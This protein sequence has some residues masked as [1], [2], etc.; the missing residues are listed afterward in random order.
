MPLAGGLGMNASGPPPIRA[1]PETRPMICYSFSRDELSGD[2]GEGEELLPGSD[3]IAQG[4]QQ[5]GGDGAGPGGLHT[6]DGH[7]GVLG[8]DDHS[9]APRPQVLAQAVG[10]L[11][12][13]PFL[14]LRPTRAM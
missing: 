4:S 2:S 6:A 13:Q 1:P 12:G 11:L 9:G 3:V 8:L 7:A 14:Y 10:D 5:G